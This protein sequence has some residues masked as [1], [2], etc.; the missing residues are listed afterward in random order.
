MN[1]QFRKHAG[2]GR[3][4]LEKTGLT[5]RVMAALELR[6]G[7]ASWAEAAQG[8][9][10]SVDQLRRWR[11]Q[12]IA[13]EWLEKRIRENLDQANAKLV[14]AAPAVAERLLEIA[15]DP[16]VKPYAA[17]GACEAVF[18]VIQTG[19][20]EAEQRQQLQ[21]IRKQLSDLESAGPVIDV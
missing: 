5:P 10:I 14:D 6:A 7:G 12:P 18:R 3:P 1:D 15:L 13:Q 11:Q 4:R 9:R 16:D 2:P 17:V 19:L 21:Q 20:I 8:A